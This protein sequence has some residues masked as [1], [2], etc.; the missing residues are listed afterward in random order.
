MIADKSDND[1]VMMSEHLIGNIPELED[2]VAQ[3]NTTGETPRPVIVALKCIAGGK[4]QVAVG[5]LRSLK[6]SERNSLKLVINA[7][8]T[9]AINFASAVAFTQSIVTNMQ[10]YDANENLINAIVRTSAT[11]VI[12]CKIKYDDVERGFCNLSIR[13]CARQEASVNT[14]E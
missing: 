8:I 6:C 11:D 10:F 13:F 5:T 1:R 9:D 4:E 7:E 3:P 2:P 14:A 12:S